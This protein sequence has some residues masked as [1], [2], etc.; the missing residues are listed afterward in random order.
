MGHSVLIHCLAGAHR[1]GTTA[2]L[3]LMHLL[4]LNSVEATQTAQSLRSM[5]EPIGSFQ[6]LLAKCDDFPRT[7]DG[8]FM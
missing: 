5:I 4:G 1:A 2:I 8:R 3:C 7:Q 6:Q